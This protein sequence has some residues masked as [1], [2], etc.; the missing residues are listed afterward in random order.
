MC[1]LEAWPDDGTLQAIAAEN[2]LSETAFF[3]PGLFADDQFRPEGQSYALRWFTPAAEVD[4]C[5]HATLAS[6]F[7]LLT[8]LLPDRETVTF[9][10]RVAGTLTVTRQDDWY[11]MDFP[12]W[13]AVRIDPSPT[14]DLAL[15]RTP[16][17]LFDGPDL[18]AVF[19]DEETV[20]GLQPDMGALRRLNSIVIGDRNY[21]GIIATAPGREVDFVS[22]YFAPALGIPEDSVTGSTHCMLTP[23]WADR[24]GKT[25]LLAH[26][27]S[28]RGG[29]LR[30]RL[31]DDRVYL[32]GQAALY[33]DGTIHV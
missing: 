24:L 12:A 4:L 27:V 18:M 31:A 21:R 11:V 32:G 6:G 1:P 2:N 16:D 23:Y 10:T 25:E 29:E 17:R 9:S 26:Q 22:R 3:V 28:R 14:L 19:E 33:L 20:R 5:G 30:C 13:P 7:V 8:R 15:G